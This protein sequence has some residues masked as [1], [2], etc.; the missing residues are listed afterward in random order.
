MSMSV[1]SM[2]MTMNTMTA[3]TNNLM[4]V[5]G[6]VVS[7]DGPDDRLRL[8]HERLELEN[9]KHE[10]EKAEKLKREQDRFRKAAAAEAKGAQ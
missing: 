3:N 1:Q 7:R 5:V 6:N 2:T 4:G 9:I 8:E 10:E